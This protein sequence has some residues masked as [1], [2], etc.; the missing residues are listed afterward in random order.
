MKLLF[1]LEVIE[2]N[3]VRARPGDS[4]KSLPLNEQITA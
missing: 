3:R 2:G 4:L 1:N